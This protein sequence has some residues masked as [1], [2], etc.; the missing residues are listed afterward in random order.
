[1]IL[2]MMYIEDAF[3]RGQCSVHV[4]GSIELK[5]IKDVLYNHI[6]FFK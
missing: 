3:V 4:A 2:F 1:M 5:L 6:S